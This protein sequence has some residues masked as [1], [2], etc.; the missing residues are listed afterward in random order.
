MYDMLSAMT[1][2]LRNVNYKAISAPEIVWD[3][4]NGEVV[5][6]NLKSGEYF[7]MN[8]YASDIWIECLTHANLFSIESEKMIERFIVQLM[9]FGLLSIESSSQHKT[10]SIFKI[11]GKPEV[12]RYTDLSEMLRLDPIH[13]VNE[14]IG[15][16][17][18][19]N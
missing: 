3:V 10:K 17:N 12:I 11:T 7:S 2:I 18:Q 4:A 6:I 14:Q 15:W 1:L 8:K 13:D 9:K 5:L 19:K 16:P